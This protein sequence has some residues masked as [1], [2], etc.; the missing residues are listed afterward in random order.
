MNSTIETGPLQTGRRQLRGIF[1]NPGRISQGPG[2][3]LI[4]SNVNSKVKGDGQECPTHT[5]NPNINSKVN[6]N[7]KVKGVG[8]ECPTHTYSCNVNGKDRVNTKIKGV[9]QECPIHTSNPNFNSKINCNPKVKGDGQECPSHTGCLTY[10]PFARPIATCSL[11]ASSPVLAALDFD[12]GTPVFL[13]SF[14]AS[15]RRGR[16]ILLAR[17]YQKILLAY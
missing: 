12:A 16:K 7:L 6:S 15:V 3:V 11:P 17:P 10:L 13:R 8:Q 1:P 2:Q 5:C 4:S 14:L 9:G